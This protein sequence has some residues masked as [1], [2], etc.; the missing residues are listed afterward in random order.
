MIVTNTSYASSYINVLND[1]CLC[2]KRLY[3]FPHLF[4][5]MPCHITI[6]SFDLSRPMSCLLIKLKKHSFYEA[7]FV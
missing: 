7:F 1:I 3:T 5:V 2:T 6:A 4:Y